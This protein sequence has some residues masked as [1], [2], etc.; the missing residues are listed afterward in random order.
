MIPSEQGSPS[1][2]EKPHHLI[3]GAKCRGAACRPRPVPAAALRPTSRRCLA[4][5]RQAPP[6]LLRAVDRCGPS[7]AQQAQK[8]WFAPPSQYQVSIP[9]PGHGLSP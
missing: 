6:T 2:F 8:Y 3:S 7:L 5:L 9:L 1:V 4:C